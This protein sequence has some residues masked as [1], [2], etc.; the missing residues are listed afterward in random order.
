MF[1][2]VIYILWLRE[3]KKYLRS[4]PQII[5]SLGQSLMYLL[6]LG[7]RPEP[8]LLLKGKGRT[9]GH[10]GPPLQHFRISRSASHGAIIR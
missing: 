8:R 9:Q 7:F 1:M 3:V 5:A 4:R 2:P 10:R 6:A